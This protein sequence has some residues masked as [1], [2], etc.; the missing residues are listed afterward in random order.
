MSPGEAGPRLA[1]LVGGTRFADIDWVAETGST[2]ADLVAAARDG[3]AGPTVLVADHQTGGRGRLDRRWQSPPATNLLV[4]LLLAPMGE[5]ET[6]G[7]HAAA[8]AVAAVDTCRQLGVAADLKWPNDVVVGDHKL[9][10]LLAEAVTGVG[11]LVVGLGLNVS[12]PH[13]VTEL[14]ATSLVA[15]GVAVGD[16]TDRVEVLGDL[17][18]RLDGRLGALDAGRAAVVRDAYRARCATLG[19]PV[20]VELVGGGQVVGRALEVDDAGALVVDDG[21]QRVVVTV[22]DVFHLRPD[23]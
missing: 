9:A 7:D 14:S 13:T 6:W 15:E 12:W 8:V 16:Q 5:P 4:S 1:E 21:R 2:N 10:G 20:R 19:R 23:A 17:L 18:V 22:G 11:R 3:R